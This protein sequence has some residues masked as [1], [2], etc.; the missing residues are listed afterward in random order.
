MLSQ[1]DIPLHNNCSE[2]GARAQARKR[3][4]S[5]QTKNEKGTEA[6]D[7]Y[8]TIVQTAKKLGVNVYGYIFDRI[9]KRF[10]MIS[11]SDLIKQT[12][13]G[14]PLFHDSG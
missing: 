8:M 2:L 11:L 10:K 9:S 6:K 13:E 7:T 3:D 12:S 5:L 1:P 14:M 4:I